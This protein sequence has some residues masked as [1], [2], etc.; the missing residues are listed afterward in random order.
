MDTEIMKNYYNAVLKINENSIKIL[1]TK[2]TELSV[3]TEWIPEDVE[4]INKLI[5]S[6]NKKITE[7]NVQINNTKISLEK[8][9]KTPYPTSDGKKK[10]SK[11]R[12]K[13]SRSKRY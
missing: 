7:I 2:I 8:L 6:C 12:R 1:R 10:R 4:M 11:R 3:L 9:Q 5:E 13:R